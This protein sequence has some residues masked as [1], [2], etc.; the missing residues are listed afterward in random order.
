[1]R[2]MDQNRSWI[3]RA[4][5]ILTAAVIL[6]GCQT[7]ARD[8]P[9]SGSVTDPCADRL[10]ELAGSL[11]RYYSLHGTLPQDLRD[12]HR[13]AGQ[14]ILPRPVCPVSGEP[15]IYRKD[16]VVLEGQAGQLVLYDAVPA[17]AGMR[18]GVV[19]TTAKEGGTMAAHVLL[20]ADE[21]IQP[22]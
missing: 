4:L 20:F 12:L 19:I 15:Y 1:M 11:L 6:V 17:H 14:G 18:W 7:P 21:P 3:A 8:I 16:G 13:M 2:E 10:H 9:G 22:P 5:L